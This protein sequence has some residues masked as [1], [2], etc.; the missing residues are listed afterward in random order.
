MALELGTGA[1][2]LRLAAS[3]VVFAIGLVGLVFGA[4]FLIPIVVAFIVANTL[5][6]LIERL[7]RLGIPASLSVPLGVLVALALIA[8]FVFV[9]VDQI[10]E[11]VAA[12][13]R[14]LERLRTLSGS[15]VSLLGDEFSSRVQARFNE[16]NLASRLSTAIG[17]ASGVL[18]NVGLVLLYVGFLL[19]ERGRIFKRIVLLGREAKEQDKLAA[20]LTA[21]SDGI[22]QYL[23]VKT[24]LSLLTA[25]ASYAVLRYLRLDF[26]ETW[27]VVIF[28]LNYIPSIGSVLGV[29]F[30]ALLA[31]VQFD[32]L[33]PFLVLAI[34]LASLQFAI[35]NVLEPM[36]MGRSLNLSPFVVIV[37]LTFWSTIWGIVGAFLAVPI[38]AAIV[39][40][41]REIKGWE[42]IA[43][44]LSNEAASRHDSDATH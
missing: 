26:A 32:S 34:G 28:L 1:S 14:Y 18:L 13:P 33:I 30:P 39:I 31:L 42:W 29:V 38:T 41:C 5:E 4:N 36:L 27:A 10:D 24:V 25:L 23:F 11:F 40:L 8:G 12:W 9:I 3:S 7:E 22:R 16:L 43:V 35:G 21:V 6:A 2:S 37:S 15:V 19:A 44:L 20:A 17:S